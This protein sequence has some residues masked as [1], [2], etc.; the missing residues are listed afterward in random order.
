MSADWRYVC[1]ENCGR[2]V[3]YQPADVVSP[4]RLTG[5]PEPLVVDYV[6]QRVAHLACI[7]NEHEWDD[8]SYRLG[9]T[10][11]KPSFESTEE[12]AARIAANLDLSDLGDAS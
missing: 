10:W 12:V 5:P 1:A 8:A 11:R 2:P 7:E 6:K 9:E 3:L 4:R